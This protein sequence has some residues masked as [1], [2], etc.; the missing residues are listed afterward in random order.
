MT[1]GQASDGEASWLELVVQHQ[2]AVAI[3]GG[4][5]AQTATCAFLYIHYDLVRRYP[6]HPPA[7]AIY[8]NIIKHHAHLQNIGLVA[9]Y[10]GSDMVLLSLMPEVKEPTHTMY[11]FA[12]ILCISLFVAIGFGHIT[13]HA[14]RVAHGLQ[15]VEVTDFIADSIFLDFTVPVS[16]MCVKAVAQIACFLLYLLGLHGTL[17]NSLHKFNLTYWA[18]S[19]VAVQFYMFNADPQTSRRCYISSAHWTEALLSH[20]RGSRCFVKYGEDD[21]IRVS[22]PGMLLRVL[23]QFLVN[24]LGFLLIWL[25]VP[26]LVSVADSPLDYIMNLFAV[27]FLTQLDDVDEEKRFLLRFEDVSRDSAYVHDRFSIQ[28]DNT[29][30]P[31]VTTSSMIAEKQSTTR[32]DM[33]MRVSALEHR[34]AELEEQLHS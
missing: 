6:Q 16:E 12:G 32:V 24:G 13:P 33:L 20:L 21:W 3:V 4:T 9:F 25:T 34:L 30:A 5:L 22:R 19:I 7:W 11:F 26:M 17:V 23:L 27:T 1:A 8:E 29:Y 10:L 28:S 14:C 15:A 2:L 31:M 18:V